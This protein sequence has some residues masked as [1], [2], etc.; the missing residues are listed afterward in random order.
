MDILIK[1]ARVLLYNEDRFSIKE[2]SIL[3]SGKKIKK[4]GNIDENE[5]SNCEVINGKHKLV[6]PGL[7]NTHGHL[8]MSLFR[9]YKDD[10]DLDTWLHKYIFPKEDN[11]KAGDCYY[12][13]LLSISEMIR[14]G[15]TNIADMY[16]FMEDA[17]QAVVESGIKANLSRSVSCFGEFTRD[18]DY[19]LKEMISLYEKYNNAADGRIKVSFAPHSIYTCTPEYIREC[20]DL[21]R[22]YNVDLQIHMC[23]T[24]K[25]VNDCKEKYKV[26]PFE[27]CES[28]N[29]FENNNTIAAHCVHLEDIDY[30]IIKK[31]NIT[32]SHNPT[33]NLKLASGVADISRALSERINITLGTDGAGSNN[34]QNL[35]NEMRLC[36]I[37]HKGVKLN[38]EIVPANE[39]L[40]MA[41]INGAKAFADKEIGIIEEG[42]K[43]D[44]IILDIDKP[45]YYPL[46]NERMINALI[47]SSNSS[48]VE[49]VIID[50]KI[51]MKNKEILTIDEEKVK[52][53]LGG[54]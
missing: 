51:V 16:F 2:T 35:F 8:A 43:A 34:A 18:T 23:E 24:L 20:G 53:H 17:A 50:G 4:I 32:I 7:I 48:D 26:T 36:G 40:K 22:E 5:I 37:L 41:T 54:L 31:R 27:L 28:L 6:M 12:P 46:D 45:N 21:A 25:E 14:S 11:L 10:V 47:Y 19:R 29:L 15:I 49:T 52:Y 1:D 38:P 30:E 42:K 9:N 3:I 33:S 44:L 39:V 13:V